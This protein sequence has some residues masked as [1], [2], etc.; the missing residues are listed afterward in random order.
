MLANSLISFLEF[1]SLVVLLAL[2]S[3]Y[4]S[5]DRVAMGYNPTAP[6]VNYFIHNFT[7]RNRSALVMT[8]T[9]LKL[10]AMPAIIGLN[11]TPKNG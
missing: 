3:D 8:E 6:S 5:A 9:E 10:I 4:A 11:S 2:E 7:F 1:D